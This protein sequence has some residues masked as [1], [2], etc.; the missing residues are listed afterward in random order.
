VTE[1]ARQAAFPQQQFLRVEKKSKRKRN[2]DEDDEY[3]PPVTKRKRLP[4]LPALSPPGSDDE[5][6]EFPP[7]SSFRIK[8]CRGRY[9]AVDRL[10]EVEAS[11]STPVS[12]EKVGEEFGI[13]DSEE[14]TS[15]IG[16]G[17]M[18]FSFSS[19]IEDDE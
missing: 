8:K 13:H 19:H 18:R 3:E 17:R 12:A 2:W 7:E 14:A 9:I 5:A 11:S 1:R 6:W 10:S 4:S 16:A 15:E